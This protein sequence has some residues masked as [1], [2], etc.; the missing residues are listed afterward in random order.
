MW[1][2]YCIRKTR[3]LC[4][5]V[6]CNTQ[7]NARPYIKIYT[8]LFYPPDKMIT[9]AC[10]ILNK[11]IAVGFKLR[12]FFRTEIDGIVHAYRVLTV[13]REFSLRYTANY[14]FC[15]SMKFTTPSPQIIWHKNLLPLRWYVSIEMTK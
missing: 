13:N 6:S 15:L 5:L 14:Q 10:Y 11:H 9:S 3:C 8:P 4:F 12:F 7:S 2:W 1:Q